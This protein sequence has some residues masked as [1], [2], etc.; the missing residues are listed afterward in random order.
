MRRITPIP[1][2]LIALAAPAAAMADGGAKQFIP[3]AH[4]NGDGT[5]TLPLHRGTSGGHDVWF[6]V[7]DASTSNGAAAFGANRSNK[8]ANAPGTAAVQRVTVNGGVID[9][10][11]TVDFAPVRRV[12]PGPAGFP[13]AT[14][15]PGAI[16]DPGYSP[17]IELPDGTI[18][19]APQIANATGV[20]DKALALDTVRGTVVY[21]ETDGFARGNAVKYVST[22][23]SLDVAAA[24]EDVTYAPPLNVAPFAAGG[25]TASARA[26]LDAFVN[27]ATGA[28][29]PQRQGLNS[30]LLDGLDPLNVLAWTPN[31]GRY[32]PLWDVH[33]AAWSAAA[34][35]TGSNARQRRLAHGEA[36]AAAGMVTAPP[37]ERFGPSGI[38][39]DCPI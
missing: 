23:A 27:G 11:A 9:F 7:L 32:S 20:A 26:E 29:D 1:A 12:V 24:I 36:L 22:D 15:D 14:A 31:Q 25:G 17:L 18:L 8:L 28:A 5:V 10:P 35:G 2:A 39:V 30:A 38:I 21:K 3:S 34:G 4:E 37:G 19:N 13:P 6:V 16:G 33:L